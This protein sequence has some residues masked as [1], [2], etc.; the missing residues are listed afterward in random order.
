MLAPVAQGTLVPEKSGAS[1]T[2]FCLLATLCSAMA[3]PAR[4]APEP[5]ARSSGRWRTTRATP[6]KG[7]LSAVGHVTLRVS[8]NAAPALDA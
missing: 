6:D 5:G 8:R 1:T 7:A 3:S 2:A 4:R